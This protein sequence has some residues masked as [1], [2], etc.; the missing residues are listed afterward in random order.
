MSTAAVKIRRLSLNRFCRVCLIFLHH[1]GTMCLTLPRFVSGSA[2]LICNCYALCETPESVSDL[3]FCVSTLRLCYYT[4]ANMSFFQA[5]ITG[6][7]QVEVD[8]RYTAVQV[9]DHPW[10][11]VSSAF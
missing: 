4:A 3:L 11:N 5:L 6:M 10:V 8:Q 9:L 7:L 1:T 2:P